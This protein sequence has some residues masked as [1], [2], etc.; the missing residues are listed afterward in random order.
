LAVL[1]CVIAVQLTGSGTSALPPEACVL[2]HGYWKNHTAAWPV[3][4]LQLGDP[5]KT[6]HTYN[7][8]ALQSLLSASAKGDASIILAMQLIAAKLNI[9]SGAHS[10]SAEAAIAHA[11]TLLA[12]FNRTLPYG[13]KSSTPVGADMTST[14]GILDDFN[15]GRLSYSC[16][17]A[18]QPPTANAGPDQTVPIGSLVTLSGA[19]SS[20]PNGDAL[21]FAWTMVSLPAGSAAIV[22]RPTTVSPSFVADLPGTYTLGLIVSDGYTNSA[23]DV[24]VVSTSNSVPVA[25]AG[26]DQTVEVGNVVRLDGSG[27]TD[28]DGDQLAFHWSFTSLPP[29]SQAAFVDSAAVAPLFTTDLPG[30]YVAQL[31]VRDAQ[32]AEASDSVTI[33]T[34]NSPPLAN[35]GADRTAR[36]GEIVTLSGAGSSDVDG[37]ALQYRWSV[38]SRPAGSAAT[39]ADSSSVRPS[40]GID[41]RGDYVIQLIVNDGT[42]DSEADTVTISTGNVRPVANAGVDRSIFVGTPVQLDGS[43]SSDVDGDALRY[44][45]SLTVRPP[46]SLATLTDPAAVN[47]TFVADVAGAYVAQ[48]I[49]EDGALASDPDTVQ[50]TTENRPPIADPGIAQTVA[51]GATV[52]L[53]GSASLDPDGDAITYLWSLVSSPQGSAARLIGTTAAQ[54]SFVVDARGDFVAQLIVADATSQSAPRSVTIATENSAPIANAGSDQT[55][56]IDDTVRLDGTASLDPDGTPVQYFWSFQ[57]RPPGSQSALSDLASSSPTFDPDRAGTYV[58]QLMVSDGILISPADSVIVTITDAADLAIAIVDPPAGVAA[59]GGSASFQVRIENLGPLDAHAVG[60]RFQ[61]PSGYAGTVTASAGTYDAATGSWQAGNIAAGD[62]AQLAIQATFQAAGPLDL[63][64]A[65]TNSDRSDPNLA[66]NSASA[67]GPTRQR[68]AN[69]APIITSV[70]PSTGTAG[71]EYAYD[72]AATDPDAGDTLTFLLPIAPQGMAIDAAGHLRWTPLGSQTGPINVAIHARDQAGQIAA[73]GFT[74]SVAPSAANQPPTAANDRYDARTGNAISIVAPGVLANDSDPDGN[75]LSARLMSQPAN[76][77]AIINADGSLIYSPFT[78]QTGELITADR[79]NLAMAFPGATKATNSTWFAADNAF[80]LNLGSSWLT[81]PGDTSASGYSTTELPWVEITFPQDV[82]PIALQVRGHRSSSLAAM[83]IFAGRFQMFD[84]NG[85][86]LFDSDIVDLQAPERDGS[87]AVPDLYNRRRNAARQP[88]AIYRASSSVPSME[89]ARAFD[90]SQLTGWFASEG[91]P[92]FVEVEL[93]TAM[94]LHQVNVF[95]NRINATSDFVAYTVQA[96]NAAGQLVFDSGTVVTTAATSDRRIGA[97]DVA[98]VRRV[99]VTGTGQQ[100][101]GSAGFGEIEV[102]STESSTARLNERVRRVRFTDT[103]D[104]RAANQTGLAEIAVI[105]SAAIRREPVVESNLAQ[106][107]PAVVRASSEVAGNPADNVIDDTGQRNWYSVSHAAGEFIEIEFP[108]VVTVN[109]LR[110]QNPSGTPQGF[111]SSLPI[112]CSGTVTLLGE[113]NG[114][115]F[116]SGVINQPSGLIGADP[117]ALPVPVVA[118]VKRV[119]YTSAGCSGSWPLGFAEIQVVG[120][121]NLTIP[122]IVPIKKYQ[123]LFGFEVHSTPVVINLTDDNHDGAVDHRDVPE[124]VVAVE[125]PA[126]QLLGVLKVVSGDD[127]R[128]LM[129]MGEPSL[130]SPWAEPAGADLDGDGRPEIIAVHSDR[131]HLIAFNADGSVK[132]ISDAHAMPQFA[133]GAGVATGAIAIANLDGAGP[134]EIIVGASV[135]DA[136][137]RL[138]ADGRTLGG[139]TG[140]T[141]LRSALSAVGNIDLTGLPELVAGPTAYRLSGGTLTRVWQRSDRA[142]GYVAI[143]NLDDDPFA[144]IVV[145]GNGTVYVLNH[146]GTD[147][148][149]WNAPTHEPVVLPGGG[150]GGA[151]TIADVD[152]DGVPEIGVAGA[153]HYVIFNRDGSVRWKH[154]ISDRTSNSTGATVFDLDNDGS[155]EVIYRDEAYLRIFRGGDGVLL[156]KIAIGSSTWSEMPVVADVDND[157]HADIVVTSDRF[158]SSNNLAD[159]GVYVLTDVANR[160]ARTRRIWNQH[161]YHVTN[162][163][164]DGAVPGIEAEHWLRP[165]LNSF[166]LNRLQLDLDQDHSD[167]FEYVVNDGAADSDRAVVSVAVRAANSA[168][169]IISSAPSAAAIDVAYLYAV[170][171]ADPDAGDIL[172]FSVPEGPAGM[173]IEEASGLLRWTPSSAQRGTQTIVVK[174]RDARGLFALQRFTV[175]VGDPVVVPNVIGQFQS[176]AATTLTSAS[177][178][179]GDLATRHSPTAATGTVLGQAPSAGSL[180]AASTLI[181]LVVST[182]PQPTGTI[183][184]VVGLQQSAAATDLIASGFALGTVS[185]QFSARVAAGIVLSQTPIAGAVADAGSA[186]A[187]VVSAGVPP[188]DRDDDHDGFTGGQGDCNDTNAAINPLAI[189]VPGDGIDQNCNGRDSI[190]GDTTAPVASIASPDDLAT[191]TMP[192]DI[193]GTATDANFLRYTV[194][195]A[196]VDATS[197]TPIGSGTSPATNTVVGRIDP[198][199]LENGLYRVRLVVEDVNGLIA[200]DERVYR[201]DGAAKVGAYRLSFEDLRVP[202]AGIPITVTRTYDSRVKEQRDFGVGWTL[203]L[204]TGTYRH[205]RTPGEGWIIRDQPFLGS[206]LPCIGGSFETRSHLTEVRLSER[207]WYTFVIEITNG[208]LGITGACEGV[209]SF[210]QVDGSTL[211]AALDIIGPNGVIYVRGGEDVVL[212]RNSYLDGENRPFNVEQVRLTRP[213][214]STL[215]FERQRGVTRVS[216]RNGNTLDIT[217]Q[218]VTHSSGRSIRFERDDRDRIMRITDPRGQT[219]SYT[220]DDAGDLERFTNQS[221]DRT[222]FSYDTGHNLLEIH[223]ALGRISRSEFDSTGRLIATIDPDGHRSL[224]QHDLENRVEVIVDRL[225]HQTTLTY[226]LRGNITQRVDA[227][228][229]VTTFTYDARDNQLTETDPEGH[230]STLAYDTRGN[231]AA[232]A[233]A[234]GETIAFTYNAHNQQLTATNA[235]GG[236]TTTAYD[237]RDNVIREIDAA[238]AQTRHFYDSRGARTSTIDA[239]GATWTYGY[240]TGGNVIRVVTPAGHERNSTYD[241][242]GNLLSESRTVTI[243]GATRTVATTFTYNAQNRRVAT[244]NA[245]GAEH[246]ISYTPTGAVATLTNAAGGITTFTYDTSDRP[247]RIVHPDGSFETKAYDAEGRMTATSDT[248]GRPTRF[249]YDALGR[250]L[251]TTFADGSVI[252]NAYDAVGRRLSTTDQLGRITRFTYDAAGRLLS[253]QDPLGVVRSST[254]DVSGNLATETDGNGGVTRFEYDAEDRRTRTTTPDGAALSEEYDLVGNRIAV[255]DPAGNITRYEYDRRR[256]LTRVVDA[257]NHAT[258]FTYDALDKPASQADA[259]GGTTRFDRDQV[260]RLVHTTLPLGNRD[261]RTYD[262]AGRLVSVRDF[263]GNL[264][265]FTYDAMF[266]MASRT[267]PTGEVHRFSYTAAGLLASYVDPTGTSTIEYDDRDRP[268]VVRRSDGAEIRYGYDA[269]GNRIALTTPA[270]TQL[271]AYDALNRVTALTDTQSLQSRFDYDANGNLSRIQYGNGVQ[272]TYRYDTVNRLTD[273]VYTR[274]SNVVRSFHYDVGPA[275]NRS[276]ATE[277]TGRTVDYGY[278]G[279]F[280][281][282]SETTTNPGQPAATVTYVYDAAGNR[283]S[284]SGSAGT[285]AYRYDANGQLLQMG[286]KTFAYD[287]N[288]NLLSTTDVTGLTT[289]QYDGLNRMT[290]ASS[291]SGTS[292]Y[293]YDAMG[294]R[295]SM[296]DAT[297][298]TNYLIDQFGANDLSVVLRESRSAGTIDYSYAGGLLL[299]MLRPTGASFYVPDGRRSTRALMDVAGTFTDRYDYDAFGNTVSRQ[300]TTPNNYLFDAQEFDPTIRLYNLRA[301]QYDPLSGRFS[302]RDPVPGI[303]FDPGSM[304]PYTY[305]HSDPI[306]RSDPSGEFSLMEQMTVAASVGVMAGMA[307]AIDSY[308]TYE[309]AE[310]AFEVGVDAAFTIG[311]IALDVV[312]AAVAAG[313][314]FREIAEALGKAYAGRSIVNQAARN[315][316]KSVLTKV[317]EI[318]ENVLCRTNMPQRCPALTVAKYDDTVAALAEE[319]RQVASVEARLATQLADREIIKAKNIALRAQETAK[320]V[321]EVVGQTVRKVTNWLG[322][323]GRHRGS[324]K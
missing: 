224:F 52:S 64:A 308:M 161:G 26:P 156:A 145:V 238:G 167:T 270:G 101:G 21:R 5:A 98:G 9:A 31:S 23:P 135:F 12:A 92:Q 257:L 299:S 201:V 176:A 209:A 121:S 242:A 264:T 4:T 198:T 252:A 79:V 136:Q 180:V 307:Y 84:A 162:I 146:D 70:P 286:P 285:I 77:T 139:T 50:L 200:V 315:T 54:P 142:D 8:S 230:T 96:F 115:L 169:Q 251:A 53:D 255:T 65:I 148:V 266:R 231:V 1:A 195:L 211:G 171:A 36:V 118:G 280:R 35:A 294:H 100:S 278:D 2:S 20:D 187:L 3:Q 61:L 58:A 174:V 283:T 290:Q 6:V 14:A 158:F 254:Y 143:A 85:D 137:G 229:H 27:S 245:V 123:S 122:P 215:E 207:E 138:I 43:G 124:I 292:Q 81:R 104:D 260:G 274:G 57:S 51:L 221:G 18:N 134:P 287:A 194:Q 293:R 164:E 196:E 277:D 107:L 74:I 192:T 226:D 10:A 271:L 103:D 193:V 72:V 87:V 306:N 155:V 151:P 95:G 256:A 210:R 63:S 232:S 281:V 59:T 89:A 32:S 311:A 324:G 48:L 246:R 284:Q 323:L 28:A 111:G 15:N 22:S 253:T 301:R 29:G 94:T 173:V 49:V 178:T 86:E 147:N 105:G 236:V 114:I 258:S 170:R 300:G 303:A 314:V 97:G 102:I 60:A 112:N 128:L 302:S 78:F 75:R 243:D 181:D 268:V 288:G 185:G 190:D 304:H 273:L 188:A 56:S 319:A 71:V 237:S 227:L 166:R 34:I 309:S 19:A 298:T 228:G 110:L 160:W 179:V 240:D 217:P 235:R 318:A 157:G 247:V 261:T 262:V 208:N 82:A 90:G 120:A 310:L 197:F 206:V 312:G 175:S 183:P 152:G 305:A 62:G 320:V 216:D 150:Q 126:D 267:L 130:V 269:V 117:F 83:T 109:Q 263:N 191:V 33:S 199:L 144:E 45:W 76:G 67:V 241:A 93:P 129:T 202:V 297:G 189:D 322:Q 68:S 239:V 316:G 291:T 182:G 279:L 163:D 140:G 119:R 30:V 244:I 91:A 219:L 177:L 46:G 218:G 16:G 69:R 289:Y 40:I 116:T 39:L 212:D 214:G 125:D 250:V 37:D 317:T 131:N 259:L 106:L 11:D 225:G 272:A 265:T 73:Q 313:P 204:R 223:D 222:T 44:A 47:P 203:G 282:T 99:R 42:V 165:G 275:G 233:N 172:T 234:L 149:L 127:G 159:T 25:N 276:R 113:D 295:I 7:A 248:A 153:G 133:L 80:D 88:G 249:A 154:I 108:S 41:R 132:W 13:V 168:P 321:V 55:A 66:N 186:V 296:I 205:N 24:V 184:D 141:G 220:Y 213:D 38:S 17:G